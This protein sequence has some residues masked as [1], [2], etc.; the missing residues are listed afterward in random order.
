MIFTFLKY[1]QPANYF[2]LIR[3]DQTFAFP[4]ADALSK[5]ILQQLEKDEGFVSEKAKA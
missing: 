2:G 4:K 3:Y 1:L 5:A